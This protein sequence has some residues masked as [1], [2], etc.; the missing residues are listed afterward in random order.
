MCV[1]RE[2][3]AVRRGDG[4]QSAR[5]EARRA[6][7]CLSVVLEPASRLVDACH[8]VQQGRLN[9]DLAPITGFAQQAMYQL[10]S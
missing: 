9:V 8:S 5:V 7:T 6:A 1:M 4:K 10:A 3:S 2:D